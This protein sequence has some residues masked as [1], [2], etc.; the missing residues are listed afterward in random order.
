VIST[1]ID[2]NSG[3]ASPTYPNGIAIDEGAQHLYFSDTTNDWIYRSDL[4]GSNIVAI[5]DSD[6]GGTD[7]GE[8]D[9]YPHE[10][11]IDEDGGWI[12][13]ADS[14]HVGGG[15]ILKSKLDGTGF[16]VLLSG[17]GIAE[18]LA[19][20]SVTQYL[21]FES[22][23][24]DGRPYTLRRMKTDGTGVEDIVSTGVRP[25]DVVVDSANQVV[26]WSGSNQ[27]PSSPQTGIYKTVLSTLTTTL[28]HGSGTEG[29]AFDGANLYFT[30]GGGVKVLRLSDL[31][32]SHLIDIGN[33]SIKFM[34][35]RSE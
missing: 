23:G 18:G 31:I 6:Q 32:V 7:A 15:R 8:G 4:D 25:R 16:A 26:Y 2:G 3:V 28:I 9:S 24:E 19:L 33:P 35:F 12:Y 22:G 17:N 14:G 20:D 21:Y 34:E 5:V 10:I 30:G 27:G 13:W 1:V 29:L 11:E